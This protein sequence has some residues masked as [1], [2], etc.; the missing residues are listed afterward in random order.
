MGGDVARPRAVLDDKGGRIGP[1]PFQGVQPRILP[2]T[3]RRGRIC[4][5][6]LT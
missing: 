4:E 2:Y 3:P 5:R 6:L 1:Q